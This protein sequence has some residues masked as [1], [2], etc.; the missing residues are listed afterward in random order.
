[1]K[2]LFYKIG[3]KTAKK[4]LPNFILNKIREKI[5]N[6]KAISLVMSNSQE[7]LKNKD[8]NFSQKKVLY[9]F[10][11]IDWLFRIQRP[12]QIAKGFLNGGGYKIVYFKT[13][14]LVTNKPGY[15]YEV[16]DGKIINVTLFLNE[17]KNI[18]KDKLDNKNIDF[19]L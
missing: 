9:V 10:P 2:N 12:Q 11:V 13:I 3:K 6:K 18:Y 19:L 1:M 7:I 16:L 8:F 5:N 15:A 4:F 17:Q 14:F